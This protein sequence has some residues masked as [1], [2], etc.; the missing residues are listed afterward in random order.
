MRSLR[1]WPPFTRSS[2]WPS[3]AS[4]A[5]LSS[6]RPSSP[7]C[8]LAGR[9]ARRSL[10]IALR[11]VIAV[12]AAVSFFMRWPFPGRNPRPVL[13]LTHVHRP[14]RAPDAEG[15]GGYTD[16]RGHRHRVCRNAHRRSGS[17][18]RGRCGAVLDRCRRS[19]TSAVTYALSL[20]LLRQRAQRD[21]FLHIVVFQNIGPA[22][23]VAPFALFFWQPPR[24][25]ASGLVYAHGPAWG[26]WVT[27]SW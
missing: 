8:G 3:C 12:V 21:K 20:V 15:A 6:W 4:P 11:S 26:S 9:T 24:S 27:C 25:H 18:W 7:S 5:V 17:D 19:A 22:V 23:L 13:P 14:F 1:E 10:P 16:H 2:R